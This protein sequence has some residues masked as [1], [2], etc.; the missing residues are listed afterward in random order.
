MNTNKNIANHKF[1]NGVT[2]YEEYIADRKPRHLRTYHC[3]MQK[4]QVQIG[5][6]WSAVPRPV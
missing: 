1:I 5:Q 3:S 4:A 6:R 2:D